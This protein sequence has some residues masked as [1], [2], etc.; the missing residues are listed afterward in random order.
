MN[1]DLF[2]L[3]RFQAFTDW[4]QKWFG[5][6]NFTLAKIIILV[7]TFCEVGFVYLPYFDDIS[8]KIKKDILFFPILSLFGC[9]IFLFHVERIFKKRPDQ[10]NIA[11]V[12]F[13]SLRMFSSVF[14]MLGLLDICQGI[15]FSNILKA[16]RIYS[17]RVI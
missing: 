8:D 10:P 3:L 5:L 14:G 7:S 2:L 17:L 11:A 12:I 6:N 13:I 4:F 16:H 15:F 1:L 9:V